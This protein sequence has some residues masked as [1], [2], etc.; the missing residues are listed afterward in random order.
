MDVEVVAGTARVGRRTKDLIRRIRPGDVAVIDHLD[1]DRVAAEGLVLAS[2]AAV[3]NA[4]PSI[5]GRYPNVGPLLIAAAGIPLIDSVGPDVM[6]AVRDGARLTID[7][8]MVRA[9][10]WSATGTRQSL[11][12][13]EEAVAAARASMGEELERFA[14][15]TLEYLRRERHLATDQPDLPEV[16]V[17]MRGRQVLVAV[18]GPDYREDLN[19]LRQTGYMRELRPVTIAVDG[20]ADALMAIGRKPDIIIGDFDSVSEAALRCGAVLVVHAYPG[21]KAPGADR[22]LELGLDHIVFEAPGT[23]EDIAMLLAYEK[24]AELIVAVGS[25]SSMTEFLDK[26]RAGMASTFLVRMKV[27]G[28]LVDAKGVSRLYQQRVR[29]GDI[30]LLVGAAL[31]ALIVVTA[32]SQPARLFIDNLWSALELIRK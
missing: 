14:E 15:N 10:A 18:R 30:A 27:G 5:S 23:S 9:G 19:A 20:A 22:L 13:L 25:H 32:V 17:D 21:G 2:P 4:A 7:G 29:K 16:G 26:G 11:V 31:F 6:D 12:S 8:E 3:V 1:L 24:G 28:I